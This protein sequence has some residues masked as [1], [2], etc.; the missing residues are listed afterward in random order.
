MDSKEK[1]F[2]IIE[3]A[4]AKAGYVILDGDHDTVIVR[5]K[6]ADQ[7]FSIRIEVEG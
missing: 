4:L 2:D 7:D 1:I 3:N 6:K 5:D